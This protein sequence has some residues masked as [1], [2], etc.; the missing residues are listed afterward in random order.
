MLYKGKYIHS[1]WK[2]IWH[3]TQEEGSLSKPSLQTELQDTE[4][5][6]K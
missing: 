2:Y 3:P 1:L 4:R 6:G 5:K